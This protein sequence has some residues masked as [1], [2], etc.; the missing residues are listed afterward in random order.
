[1]TPDEIIKKAVLDLEF[2]QKFNQLN[3]PLNSIGYVY[4]GYLLAK[5]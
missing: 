5:E 4:L 1:M 3:L 2:M